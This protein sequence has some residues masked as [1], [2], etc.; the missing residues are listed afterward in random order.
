MLLSYAFQEAAA[1][2]C[3]LTLRTSPSWRGIFTPLNLVPSGQV[4]TF[5]RICQLKSIIR[6][7]QSCPTVNT[8]YVF[9][10]VRLERRTLSSV[11]S[12]K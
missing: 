10:W 3:S 6:M 7:C 1:R 4:S 2:P 5:S 8:D 12:V 11:W 9:S